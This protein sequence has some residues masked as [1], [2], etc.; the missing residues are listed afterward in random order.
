MKTA[1]GWTVIAN[2]QLVDGTGARGSA[3]ACLCELAW[4]RGLNCREQLIEDPGDP[5]Q[6]SVALV[7]VV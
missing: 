6:G 3:A 5:Q 1:T 7:W 4:R 2:G